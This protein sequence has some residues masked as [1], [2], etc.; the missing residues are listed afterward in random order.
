MASQPQNAKVLRIMIVR[1]GKSVQERLLKPGETVTIGEAPRCTFVLPNT[2]LPR[3][4][5]PLFQF[6]SGSYFLQFTRD[7]SGKLSSSGRVTSLDRLKADP[8]VER[9]GSVWRLP[10]TEQDRGK[11]SFHDI[12]VLFQFAPRPPVQASKPLERFNFSPVWFEDDDPAFYGFLTLF[13]V[14]A[15][16]FAIGIY[17]APPAPEPKFSEISNRFANVIQQTKVEREK[18]EVEK[19]QPDEELVAERK[20]AETKAE[21]EKT[22]SVPKI[23]KQPQPRD[24]VQAA[25]QREQRLA[26]MRKQMQTKLLGTRGQSSGGTI[27]DPFEGD[28]LES[29]SG[30]SGRDVALDGDPQGTRGGDYST[31]N[32]EVD[33]DVQVGGAQ[34][35]QAA[36]APPIKVEVDTSKGDTFDLEDPGGSVDAVI[37]Q[38]SGQLQACY[39]EQLRGDPSLSGRVEVQ[40]N[41]RRGRVTSAQVIGNT[42]GNTA[43]GDCIVNRIRRWRFADD[44]DGPLSWSWMFRKGG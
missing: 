36:A 2:G 38:R 27:T 39:E 31:E 5:F 34:A 35:S 33:S 15:A 1:G 19:R 37:R 42:S 43:L 20:K 18:D 11:V 14:L 4:D 29:L 9:Q 26:E 12:T 44:V 28:T 17:L 40:F 24:E 7:M 16:I 32:M 30:V 22:E 13:G 3:A 41:I 10:L 21:P 8:S 6:N 23:S 25:Q